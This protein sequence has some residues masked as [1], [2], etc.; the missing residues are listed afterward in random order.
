MNDD[1][2]DTAIHR[3]N[4]I[5]IQEYHGVFDSSFVDEGG[6]LTDGA[7]DLELHAERKLKFECE[8]GRKFR[9]E[10]TAVEHITEV[11]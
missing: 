2:L 6:N 1:Q 5:S 4:V 9:K 11:C 7:L 8:C 10:E 3:I